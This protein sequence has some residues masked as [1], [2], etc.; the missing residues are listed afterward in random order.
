MVKVPYLVAGIIAKA[1]SIDD[2]DLLRQGAAPVRRDPGRR[3]QWD[4]SPLTF[5]WGTCPKLGTV[6]HDCWRTGRR[7]PLLATASRV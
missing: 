4:H 5:T 2:R 1:D 6:S 3:P 7:A